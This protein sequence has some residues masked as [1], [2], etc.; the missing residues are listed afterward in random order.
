MDSMNTGSD[1]AKGGLMVEV[2]FYCPKQEARSRCEISE[3]MWKCV[4]AAPTK[5]QVTNG[6][7]QSDSR[8]KWFC[9]SVDF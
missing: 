3:T 4:S 6:L 2:Q 9:Y 8:A 5:Y 7:T 1:I